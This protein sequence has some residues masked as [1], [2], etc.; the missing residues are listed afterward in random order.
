VNTP[1]ARY[2]CK[3]LSKVIHNLN[4]F[5]DRFD[6][7]EIISQAELKI[8]ENETFLTLCKRLSCL[9]AQELVKCINSLPDNLETAK[10]QGT[11]GVTYGK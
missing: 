11:I 1:A 5:F 10:P 2:S 4:F 7:G 8:A 6:V 3:F 9:G